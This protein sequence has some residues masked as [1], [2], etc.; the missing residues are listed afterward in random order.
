MDSAA[1]AAG[2]GRL[3][4]DAAFRDE[5]VRRGT[6]RAAQ[7]RWDE[8]GRRLKSLLENVARA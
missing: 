2:I 8:S 4:D 5:L 6:A 1:I 3:L 7:F